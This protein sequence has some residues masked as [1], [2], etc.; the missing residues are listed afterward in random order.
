MKQ[1]IVRGLDGVSRGIE[2]IAG[3][4]MA[5]ITLLVTVSAIGRYLFAFP[6]PDAFDWSRLLLGAAIMW[7]LASVG[8]R[9]AHIKVDL[10]ALALKP[11]WRRVVDFTAWSVLLIFTC[12]LSWKLL[13]RVLSAQASGEAT[14]DL[15]VPVYPFLWLIWAGVTVSIITVLA[16]LVLI[17]TGQSDLEQFEDT[18]GESGEK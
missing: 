17:A 14:F 9:G 12:L 16:R 3:L 5:L 6:I 13:A 2:L 4:L 18:S 1:R 8:Y 7:G 15:R 10:F 11:K